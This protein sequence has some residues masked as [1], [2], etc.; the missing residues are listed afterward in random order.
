[1]KFCQKEHK[2]VEEYMLRVHEA[3]AVVKRAYPD[4]VP[5]EGEGLRQD[6]FY[7]RL[8]PSLRDVHSASLWLTYLRENKQTQ[9]LTFS[10]ISPR[11]W[12]HTINHIT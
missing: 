8:I 7:Y 6:H 1:M 10:I 4:Q 11:N 12:R 2:T 5:N 3:V 9:A